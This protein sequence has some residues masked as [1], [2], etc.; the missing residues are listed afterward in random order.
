ML[1]ISGERTDPSRE[2]QPSGRRKAVEGE[3]VV[4]DVKE[5]GMLFRGRGTG[6]EDDGE[7]YEDGLLDPEA[8]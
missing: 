5:E 3:E 1:A 7:G 4:R 2:A 6:E 8:R